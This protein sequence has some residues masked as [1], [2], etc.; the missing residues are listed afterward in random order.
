MSKASR[1]RKGEQ[2]R[3]GEG[4]TYRERRKVGHRER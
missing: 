1:G 2:R 3:R 4:S